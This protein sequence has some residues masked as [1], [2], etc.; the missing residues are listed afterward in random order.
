[1]SLQ[2][3]LEL[4]IDDNSA[5]FADGKRLIISSDLAHAI[6]KHIL[7]KLPKEKDTLSFLQGD[8]YP[9]GYNQAIQEIRKGLTDE[10]V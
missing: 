7:G 3:Y 9:F 2:T 10:K 1:M 6:T 8:N 5:S 4:I